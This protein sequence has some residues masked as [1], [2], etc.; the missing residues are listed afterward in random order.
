MSTVS[1][2]VRAPIVSA[3]FAWRDEIAAMK[4]TTRLMINRVHPNAVVYA[5]A[6]LKT[7][8]RAADGP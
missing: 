2:A 8:K 6:A 1:A 4:C 5:N 3:V 7:V